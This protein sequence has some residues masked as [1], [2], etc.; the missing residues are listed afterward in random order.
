MSW[1][2]IRAA[3]QQWVVA[4]TGLST[5]KVTWARQKNTPRPD[6]D[7]IVMKLLVVDDV[8]LPWIDVEAK[9]LSF[10]NVSITVVSGNNLTATAHGLITGDGPVLLTGAALPLPLLQNTNYWIIRVDANTLQLA[11]QFE[12]TGGGDATGN[13][14]TPITLTSTGSGARTIVSQ[15]TTLRAGQEIEFVQRGQS[16]ATLQLFS[17]VGNDTGEDGAIA[18]LRRVAQRYKLPP[19]LDI[20]DLAGVGV[21]GMER[22]RSMLGVRNAVMFEPRAWLDVGLSLPYEERV[23]GTVIGRTEVTQLTPT[24]GWVTI[25]ENEEL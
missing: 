24:P 7:G 16:R 11:S 9:V 23:S 8:G 22:A 1:V 3:L 10:P 20:L 2:S 25:I 15:T 5:Q 18:I 17:Y 12:N 19:N 6:E 13:P 14:I 21:T 4:C